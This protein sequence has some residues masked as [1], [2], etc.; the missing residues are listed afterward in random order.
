M[1]SN[2]NIYDAVFM[3]ITPVSSDPLRALEELGLGRAEL[4][5]VGTFSYLDNS[6]MQRPE[7][8]RAFG[9]R[10]SYGSLLRY[11]VLH[12]FAA[13][14]VIYEQLNRAGPRM[15]PW[16]SLAREDGFERGAR[17]RRFVYWSNVRSYLLGHAPW[18][19]FVLA[20]VVILGSLWLMFGSAEDRAFAALALAVQLIA[21]LESASASLGAGTETERH[22][23]GFHVATDITILLLP[24]LIVK[25]WKRT[26]T[27]QAEAVS[28]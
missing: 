12:P 18:H 11:C 2:R 28:G 16:G 7:W 8:A 21:L 9:A 17:P 3:H 23:L 1:R 19:V 20:F 15:L 14:H 22:L 5:L 6:P 4:P 10:C 24:P 27:V 25:I 13:M 26:R